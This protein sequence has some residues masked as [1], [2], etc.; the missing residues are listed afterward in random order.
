MNTIATIKNKIVRTLSH[1]PLTQG[2]PWM[3][4]WLEDFYWLDK[5]KCLETAVRFSISNNIAGDY[6]EF[7]VLEGKSDPESWAVYDQVVS[8]WILGDFDARIP[9][10]ESH[11]DMQIRFIP[12]IEGL[13]QQ[14]EIEYMLLV[15]HG[16]LFSSMLSLIFTNMDDASVRKLDI[17]HTMP[18]IAE[19]R[20]AGLFCTRWGQ[21]D[22]DL[23]E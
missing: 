6:F 18:I 14:Y 16:G 22:F 5:L 7:G 11:L 2:K 19:T 17:H 1:L 23:G 3:K 20:P 13:I 21:F 12:F 4:S 8:Q 10:G 15:G 9:G